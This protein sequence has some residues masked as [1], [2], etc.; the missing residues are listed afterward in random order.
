MF[1][2]TL[3]Q[4]YMMKYGSKSGLSELE[5]RQKACFRPIKMLEDAFV[6]TLN[7]L[8]FKVTDIYST[9][10]KPLHVFVEK[11]QF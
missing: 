7:Q 11:L 2:L 1:A 3:V 9:S 8:G 10:E 6:E 5:V 4:D